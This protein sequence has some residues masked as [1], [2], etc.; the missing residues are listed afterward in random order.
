MNANI[1]EM[2]IPINANKIQIGEPLISK[3]SW[4]LAGQSV[5]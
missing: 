1:D 5:E 3:S 2:I 4:G